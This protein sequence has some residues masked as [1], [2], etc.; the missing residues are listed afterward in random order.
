MKHEHMSQVERFERLSYVRDFTVAG[1][2]IDP[3][4]WKVLNVERHVVGE[5]KDGSHAGGVPGCRA[6]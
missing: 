4:G 2:Q 1:D 5:V 3:R 6:R